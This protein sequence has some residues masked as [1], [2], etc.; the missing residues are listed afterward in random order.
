M[1]QVITDLKRWR[2]T[3]NSPSWRGKSIGF[4]PTMGALHEGHLSLVRRCVD[5]ND[6]TTVTIFVNPT[7][8][9]DSKDL[10]S[11]PRDFERDRD[12]LEEA[13]VQ[14]ILSPEYDEIYPDDYR[15]R[16][17]EK[18]FSKKLCGAHRPRHFDGVLTVVMK[19]L[20]IVKA[21]RA[22]FGEKDY[23]QYEL[24]RRMA[25]AFFLRT[26]IIPCPTIRESDGLAF[27]SR[28]DLLT[29]E[30]RKIAPRFYR[31][32]CSDM[33]LKE[34]KEKLYETGFRVDYVEEIGNRRY[35]AV[36]LGNVRLMDNVKI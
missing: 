29:L 24:I 5:E 1:I 30:E 11:Y 23:Q 31:L 3:R 22:Y 7:Q 14:I 16:V 28:N 10:A 8:F 36:H 4:V 6:I 35:G 9:N 15:Y 25:D 20:N 33:S 2:Q 18:N 21:H 27:S 19:L 17:C 26:E 32:L 12:L 13:G 34:I